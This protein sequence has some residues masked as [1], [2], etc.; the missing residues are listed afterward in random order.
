MRKTLRELQDV[1]DIRP[2]RDRDGRYQLVATPRH[3]YGQPFWFSD[4]R[5]T[6]PVDAMRSPDLYGP[7]G[8]SH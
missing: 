3:G 1:F 7:R 5:F 8:P 4:Y 2:I 6:D